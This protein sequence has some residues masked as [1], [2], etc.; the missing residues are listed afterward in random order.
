MKSH[1]VALVAREPLRPDDELIGSWGAA[2]V[3]VRVETFPTPGGVHV[4]ASHNGYGDVTLAREVRFR[5]RSGWTVEDRV[6]G[7][8][9]TAHILRWHFEYGVEIEETGD[10]YLASKD[11]VEL[12]LTFTAP[13]RFRVRAY[14]NEKWLKPNLK[15]KGAPFPWVLDITFGGAGDDWIETRLDIL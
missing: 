1:N 12:G 4:V 13:S 10:G 9:A 8:R 11:G 14:R 7:S 6:T 2:P 15:R 5:S 3:P